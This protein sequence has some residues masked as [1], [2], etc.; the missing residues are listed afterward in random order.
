MTNRSKNTK[1]VL[2]IANLLQTSPLIPGLARNLPEFGWKTVIITGTPL[3]S[4]DERFSVI[5]TPYTDMTA[6]LKKLLGLKSEQ[7]FQEQIGIPLSMR[8]GKK[9]L[10][11]LIIRTLRELL[12]YPDE[13]KFWNPHALKAASTFLKNHD[14]AA[15]F[16]CSQP[17]TSHIIAKTL[18][19]RSHLPWIAYFYDLWSENHNY[20]YHALRKKL[21]QK[22]ERKTLKTANVLIV[23]SAFDQKKLRAVNP[24]SNI[25]IISGG[26]EPEEIN[27]QPTPLEEHF[28]ITY[29][30]TIY[31]EQQDPSK[32]F[33]A[34]SNL[35]K[36]WRINPNDLQ[37]NFYGHKTEWLEQKINSYALSRYVKQCGF[38]PREHALQ[39]QRSSHILL[40]FKWENK[41]EKGVYCLKT[42][43]YLSARR[44]I[45]AIGGSK[46]DVVCKLLSETGS[47]VVGLDVPSI[48][49]KLEDFYQEYKQTKNIVFHGK[50][51]KIN[52]Y[53]FRE[54]A[55]KVA[56]ILNKATET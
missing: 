48:E 42:F 15:I 35:I 8:E 6:Y 40:V 44:P 21:D 51:E 1:T 25:E 4:A 46:D 55:R 43:E 47:G 45:L 49:K 19:N 41:K 5:Q 12:A 33:L 28:T 38:V 2:I 54:M 37:V 23:F 14:T 20:P 39:K 3:Q 34:L 36:K 10:P 18:K 17:P 32:L 13:Q 30:G 53:S 52:Q 24:K 29:T 56:I 26:F 7:G 50:L 27:D 9:S 11:G 31:K 16:S 22:L